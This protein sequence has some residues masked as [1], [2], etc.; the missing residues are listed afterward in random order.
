MHYR[1]RTRSSPRRGQLGHPQAIPAGVDSWG[2]PDFIS[3]NGEW[4]VH[5]R[6]YLAEWIEK[7]IPDSRAELVWHT[8][9]KLEEKVAIYR[10]TPNKD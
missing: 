1:G 7:G 4:N 8:G 10:W 9:D 2:K 3:L 5:A 6:P